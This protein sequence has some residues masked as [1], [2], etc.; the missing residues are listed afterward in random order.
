MTLVVV[1]VDA[2]LVAVAL[3]LPAP[4]ACAAPPESSPHENSA[5]LESKQKTWKR[6]TAFFSSCTMPLRSR[7][8][9]AKRSLQADDG[10]IGRQMVPGAPPWSAP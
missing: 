1:L 7:H 9:S 2:P 3:E 4:A 10:E 6:L 5:T 8:A